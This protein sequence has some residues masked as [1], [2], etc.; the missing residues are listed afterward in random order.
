MKVLNSIPN[1]VIETTRISLFI[2]PE[3]DGRD[4]PLRE[5][6]QFWVKLSRPIPP[7]FAKPWRY[8]SA[9]LQELLRWF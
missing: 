4:R 8:R 6:F 2:V 3:A 1:W 7:R 5:F 9:Q